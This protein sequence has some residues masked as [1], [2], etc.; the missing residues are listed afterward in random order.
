MLDQQSG[1]KENDIQLISKFLNDFL[2]FEIF[3][4]IPCPKNLQYDY[5]DLDDSGKKELFEYTFN[6]VFRDACIETAEFLG[7]GLRLIELNLIRR[8]SLNFLKQNGLEY[9]Q[10]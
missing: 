7:R 1:G 10:D 6:Y 2:V 3:I 4:N 5:E 8:R 9:Y